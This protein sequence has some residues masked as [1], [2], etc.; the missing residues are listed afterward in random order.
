MNIAD[1]VKK[2][3]FSGELVSVE[4]FGAGHI[5]RTYLAKYSKGQAYVIQ[6]INTNVFKNADQLMENIFA[7][8]E[9]LRPLIREQGGDPERETLHFMKTKDGRKYLKTDDGEYL[10]AYAFIK[11]SVSYTRADTPELFQKC[12]A[13]FGRFQKML[14]D[15]DAKSLYET[16]P[17]FHNTLWRY[18]NEFLP[19]LDKADKRQI[20]SCQ[21]EI[22][23]I[24]SQRTEMSVLT[25]L[26][27]SGEL[28]L[29]VTHNDT[30]LSNLLFD[31]LTGECICIIDLDTVMPGLALYDFGDAIRSGAGT[32]V[33]NEKAFLDLRYFEAFASGF[34]SEA[35]D[36]LSP[37]EKQ[38]L[39]F[40]A[41]LMTMELG[42]RYLT[43]YLNGAVY[44]EGSPQQHLSNAKKQLSLA[45]DIQEKMNDMN[46]IIN[47]II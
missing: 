34:L 7:V 22:E 3:D 21:K 36:T 27:E 1:A 15:F 45:L 28:P 5:N 46:N 19:A 41:Y 20:T 33:N 17:N 24:K 18:E 12:G 23:W 39:A 42:M 31:A 13:A 25:D 16:I 38:Y 37:C 29:R 26:A 35:G 2:F 44:F 11:D 10:R 9:Y 6:K 47:F 40:S 32:V 4:E 8:T 30:K 14:A 43:D